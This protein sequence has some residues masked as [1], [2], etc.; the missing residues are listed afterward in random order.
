MIMTSTD[1]DT[2]NETTD[3]LPNP[4][5][6]LSE[7]SGGLSQLTQDKIKIQLAKMAA[8]EQL[9]EVAHDLALFIEHTGGST[10]IPVTMQEALKKVL[11]DM[12][13]PKAK[14]ITSHE[15]TLHPTLMW[16]PKMSLTLG[17][18]WVLVEVIKTILTQTHK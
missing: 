18:I 10:P 8:Q 7:A 15:W 9:I 12:R 17:Y 2:D 1:I 3:A 4:E 5:I 11:K 6:E 14:L 16:I 13:P